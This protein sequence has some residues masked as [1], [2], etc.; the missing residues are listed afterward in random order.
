MMASVDSSLLFW[1]RFSGKSCEKSENSMFLTFTIVKTWKRLPGFSNRLVKHRKII[2]ENHRSW[3]S[4]RLFK[5]VFRHKDCQDQF[6]IEFFGNFVQINDFLNHQKVKHSF[7]LLTP[8]DKH[9]WKMF[10]LEYT[11]FFFWQMIA[12]N[13]RKT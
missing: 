1:R 11:Q 12:I 9:C 13:V 3:N 10:F 4:F 5:A 7:C 2:R 6:S 8:K